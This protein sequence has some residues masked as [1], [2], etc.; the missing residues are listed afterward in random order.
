MNRTIKVI[1]LSIVL[2]IVMITCLIAG[3]A[4]MTEYHEEAHKAN[5]NQDSINATIKYDNFLHLGG[6]TIAQ[7]ECETENCDFINRF[8]ESFGYQLN[9]FVFNLW[10]MLLAFLAFFSISNIIKEI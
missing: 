3:Q 9:G 1:S 10:F 2:A 6:K 8:N 7:G 4:V 5:Y